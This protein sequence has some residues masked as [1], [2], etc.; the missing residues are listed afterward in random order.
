[1]KTIL[2][3]VV[4]TGMAVAPA[5]MANNTGTVQLYTGNTYEFGNGGEFHAVTTPD[6]GTTSLGSFYTFCVETGQTF[7]AGTLYYYYTD[8]ASSP[9]PIP[10]A[11][12]TA[13]LYQTYVNA[14]TGDMT[15]PTTSDTPSGLAGQLQAAI[16]YLQGG[17]SEGG[18]PFGGA[19]NQFYDQAVTAAGLASVSVTDDYAGSAV[20]ILNVGTTPGGSQS[21]DQ[22]VLIP[23]G[24]TVPTPDGGTTVMLLG[25]AL[26]GMGF[27]SRRFRK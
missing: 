8:S 23:G 11:W 20:Q 7:S 15:Y 10:L 19:G 16:W 4:L 6:L 18:F 21:Q 3:L 5:V 14:A 13:Y 9:G 22:L 25:M 26:A 24:S 1:M 17:Q 27:V 12:G 2:T